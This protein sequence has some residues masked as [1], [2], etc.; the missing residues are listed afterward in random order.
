MDRIGILTFHWADNFGAVLQTYALQQ[1]LTQMGADVNIINFVPANLSINY[2]LFVN[3][4]KLTQLRG[5]KATVLTYAS[6]IKRFT[7]VKKRV[8]SY[9]DFRE[10]ST[11]DYQEMLLKILKH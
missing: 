8:S 3:P 11:Y 6:H 5:L 1:V 2:Q 7:Q 10:E 9:G 4:V